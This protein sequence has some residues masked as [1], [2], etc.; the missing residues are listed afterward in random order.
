LQLTKNKLTHN[1]IELRIKNEH[2]A[3]CPF[4]PRKYTVSDLRQRNEFPGTLTER[5]ANDLLNFPS[6]LICKYPPGMVW[7][8][9]LK[10]GGY[11]GRGLGF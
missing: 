11:G 10:E 3:K 1:F 4:F 6:E 8:W 5:W 7:T 2:L 9:M